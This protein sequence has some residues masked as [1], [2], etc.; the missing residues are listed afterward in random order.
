MDDI[1]EKITHFLKNKYLGFIYLNNFLIIIIIILSYILKLY[2]QYN[3]KLTV[4]LE[5]IRA[6]DKRL[7]ILSTSDMKEILNKVRDLMKQ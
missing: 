3:N 2:P 4:K 6:F 7:P 5:V 1:I